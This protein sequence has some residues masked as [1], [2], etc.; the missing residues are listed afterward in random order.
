M[1]SFQDRML[2]RRTTRYLNLFTLSKHALLISITRLQLVNIVL[3]TVTTGT[4]SINCEFIDFE[5]IL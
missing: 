3:A 2:Y 4:V 1:W 5:L